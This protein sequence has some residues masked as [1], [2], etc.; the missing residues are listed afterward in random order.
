[1]ADSTSVD[2]S[3][4]ILHDRVH[5]VDTLVNDVDTLVNDADACW[6]DEAAMLDIAQRAWDLA[7]SGA[8]ETAARLR[9]QQNDDDSLDD[10]DDTASVAS[11]RRE[12]P[13][14]VRGRQ[15]VHRLSSKTW[16]CVCAPAPRS[17]RRP[18]A[19]P[20]P[21][22]QHEYAMTSWR[23]LSAPSCLPSRSGVPSGAPSAAPSATPAAVPSAAPS[24][25]LAPSRR[26]GRR[27]SARRTREGGCLICGCGH[28]PLPFAR[29]HPRLRPGSF[30]L[31]PFHQPVHGGDGDSGGAACA[32]S[33]CSARAPTRRPT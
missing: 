19:A 12:Q 9:D 17:F 24:R 31:I 27:C 28:A 14:P 32:H 2:G 13:A 7:S 26:P 25:R 22:D 1:M 23:P 21:D 18:S 3:V 30:C 4:S 20:M 5:D 8:L 15:H 6:D 11:G 16:G 33:G 10:L 29:T